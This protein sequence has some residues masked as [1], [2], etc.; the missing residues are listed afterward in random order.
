MYLWLVVGCGTSVGL[1]DLVLLSDTRKEREICRR[2]PKHAQ[3]HGKRACALHLARN[4]RSARLPYR[5]LCKYQI[6]HALVSAFCNSISHLN[7][8]K[9][10]KCK[11]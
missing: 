9:N 4:M 1:W 5:V 11:R 3:G 8:C 10:A 6:V 2:T 7:G